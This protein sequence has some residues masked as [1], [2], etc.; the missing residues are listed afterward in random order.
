MKA[1]RW[2]EPPLSERARRALAIVAALAIAPQVFFIPL[3]LTLPCLTLALI[4]AWSPPPVLPKLWRVVLFVILALSMVMIG[5]YFRRVWGREPGVSLLTVMVAA[6]LLEVRSTRDAMVVWCASAVLL[7]ALTTFDQELVALL[8]TLAVLVALFGLL[9]V[10]HDANDNHPVAAHTR[11]ALKRLALGVPIALV[12]FVLFPRLTGPMWGFAE[13]RIG[14]TGL[15]DSMRMG[16]ISELVKSDEVAFRVEFLDTQP[17]RD[18]LYW[19]GPVLDHY[20]IDGA[21]ESWRSI[22]QPPGQFVPL[23]ENVP[24]FKPLR[25]AVTLQPHQERWLFALEVP[26]SYPKGGRLETTTF[27]NAA[28]QLVNRTPVR[29]PVRYEVTS[30]LLDRF[31]GISLDRAH[32][33]ITGP[34]SLNPRAR[35]WAQQQFEQAGRD[36]KAYVIAV[37]TH[38]R[39]DTFAYTT[40][41][42]LLESNVVDAFWFDT[43]RGFC[44]HYAGA[45]VFLMRAA[46][47]PA[48]VVT[49]YQGGEYN[50]QNNTLVVRQSEAHA[51][52]EVLIDGWWRRVDPTAAVA[53]QRIELDLSSALPAGERSDYARSDS[54]V[55]RFARHSWD[56]FQHT[57]TAWLLGY[58]RTQQLRALDAIGLGNLKPSQ[59]IG[60]MLLFSVAAVGITLALYAAHERFARRRK[61]DVAETFWL[62]LVARLQKRGLA[63]PA[64]ITPRSL[65]AFIARLPAPERESLTRFASLIE[66]TRYANAGGTRTTPA[67]RAAIKRAYR[68]IAFRA[69]TP[70]QG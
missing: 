11:Q 31:P 18:Q 12:L 42:P 44:E 67:Q 9:D 5:L 37:L 51:W 22:R 15:S 61:G 30:Q 8:Y 57:Y 34:S 24:G 70:S 41:P 25:Y 54:M 28:Q 64:N 66:K 46:G 29:E 69:I 45:F 7:V 6:K 2:P 1:L 26:A 49:G 13:G 23:P 50:P 38:V 3:W 43:K 17:S 65:D 63:L 19:R 20:V 35:A 55:L 4:C 10:I 14:R 59:W 27:L 21:Q 33:T 62:R 48:R 56:A 16:Q 60:A 40:R 53:P 68:A 39:Q 58:D 52:A 32:N 36:P 47:V